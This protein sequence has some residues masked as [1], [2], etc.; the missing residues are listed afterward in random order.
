MRLD[1]CDRRCMGQK[2]QEEAVFDDATRVQHTTGQDGR[3][4]DRNGA[5]QLQEDLNGSMLLA[6]E[7]LT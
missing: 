4:G 1:R 2:H 6:V 7:R 5:R 3:A